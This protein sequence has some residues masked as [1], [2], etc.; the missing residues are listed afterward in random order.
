MNLKK[1]IKS[2]QVL[3]LFGAIISVLFVLE[4]CSKK[5]GSSEHEYFLFDSSKLGIE[6][7]DHDLGIKFYPPKDWNLRPT[8][9]SKKIESHGS[10]ENFVYQ[11][12]YVF[13][14]DSIGGLLSVGKVITN[15]TSMA[16]SARINYY[17]SLLSSKYK[18]D[19]FSSAAFIH[20]KIYF[21]QIKF[22][23]HNLVSIKVFFE[24][25]NKEIIQFDY[26]VPS[27]Y[28]ESTEDFIKSS[29]GS[30]RLF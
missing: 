3:L 30:V 25:P 23:K 21:N 4:S 6:V 18:G 28:L 29:I 14:S 26:T 24:N 19:G 1:S 11:P 13:F 16:K 10:T 27:N 22:T 12:T 17:K 9:I 8:S 20:S 7:A 2:C 15:D 5:D